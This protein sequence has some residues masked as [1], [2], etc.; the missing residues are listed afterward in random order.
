MT[1]RTTASRR[2]APDTDYAY[3]SSRVRALEARVLDG[4]RMARL[5]EAQSVDEVV[6]AM[7]EAGYPSGEQP[8]QSLSEGLAAQAALVRDLFPEPGYDEVL[9]LPQDAHNLK[10]ILKAFLSGQLPD[11]ERFVGDETS[12][13]GEGLLAG[14]GSGDVPGD[15]LASLPRFADV[16]TA[17][18]LRPYALSP[19]LEPFQAV[20]EAVRDRSAGRIHPFLE[21]AA[22]AA[23]RAFAQDPVGSVLDAAVDRLLYDTLSRKVAALGNPW[24]RDFQAFRV[25]LLN[26][27]VLLR[28]LAMGSPAGRLAQELLPGGSLPEA[29]FLRL[30]GATGEQV[31]DAFRATP[32]APL[33]ALA[34]EYGKPGVAARF[35]RLA[36]D[37]LSARVRTGR[38]VLFGPE[39]LLGYLHA[40]EMEA[41]NL[42]LVL[43]ALRNGIRSAQVRD[44]LR[45]TTF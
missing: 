30:E 2:P 8:E 9:L 39:I 37:L 42:R 4:A 33:S 32:L 19:S 27:G 21:A 17:D 44:L 15:D 36:D 16:P 13:L 12:A 40:R 45:D 14:S 31:A 18:S 26:L 1:E 5:S 24:F 34:P 41:K 3:A 25:D 10:V 6:R 28:V 20:Y 11:G 29:A 35:G 7:A 43:T 22:V 38:R 23:V